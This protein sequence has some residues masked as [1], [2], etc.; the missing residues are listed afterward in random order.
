M[1]IAIT[2]ILAIIG[3]ACAL[4]F[5]DIAAFKRLMRFTR[6]IANTAS[7]V[8]LGMLIATM[9]IRDGVGVDRLLKVTIIIMLGAA[10]WMALLAFLLW[11]REGVTG[12]IDL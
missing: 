6:P 12:F 3:G 8:A 7:Y 10:V 1:E 2:V 4:A 11:L 5:T 9:S